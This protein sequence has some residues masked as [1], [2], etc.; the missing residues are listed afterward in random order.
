MGSNLVEQ[1]RLEKGGFAS[2]GSFEGEGRLS[3]LL[4]CTR[5]ASCSH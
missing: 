4:P 2:N 1:R 5:Q 3:G